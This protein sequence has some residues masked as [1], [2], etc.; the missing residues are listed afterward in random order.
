[1]IKLF[2]R[3]KAII[4]VLFIPI[5]NGLWCGE[6]ECI[7]TTFRK[8]QIDGTSVMKYWHEP[9]VC[10]GKCKYGWTRGYVNFRFNEE[11]SIISFD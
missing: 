6:P 1:M 11:K 2:K 4:E 3:L 8:I 10:N 5:P 7:L 9:F